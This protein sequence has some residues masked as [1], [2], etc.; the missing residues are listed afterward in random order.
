VRENEERLVAQEGLIPI[1]RAGTGNKEDGRKR[2]FARR[3]CECSCELDSRRLVLVTHLFFGVWIR[4]L[5]RLGPVVFYVFRVLVDFFQDER[6]LCS[7]L[8]PGS[9][10]L[11]AVRG[12][13]PF[14][15]SGYRSDVKVE[16]AICKRGLGNGYAF[17][18]LVGAV[19]CG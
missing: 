10:D 6:K 16:F 18:A 17:C 15:R 8:L 19:H 2:A 7:A 14:K 12:K 3:N 9:G 11:L 4:L 13:S 5:W 1:L